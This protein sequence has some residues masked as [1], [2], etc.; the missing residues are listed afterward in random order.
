MA[1]LVLM[2]QGLTL[3]VDGGFFTVERAGQVVDRVRVSEVDEVLLFGNVHVTPAATAVLLARGID[4]VFLSARGRYRGRL[5][6]RPGRNVEL[7]IAQFERLR[8]PAAALSF[9]R[10]VVAGKIANQRALLL[11]AQR[12]HGLEEVA[13]ALA[14]LRWVQQAVGQAPNIEAARG[15]EG[16]A[17]AVYFGR[18]GA[19][20]RNPAF[21]FNGRTRRPPRDPVNAMLSFGYTMLATLV[22]SVVLRAGLDP[23]LGALHAPDYGRPSLVLDLME[24]FRPILVDALVLRL[25]NRREVV[26]EDFEQ[27]PDEVE[28]VWAEEAEGAVASGSSPAVWLGE[29]GRRVFFRAWSR[30]LQETH[31]YAP[32]R[33]RLTFEEIVQQQTYLLARV[34]RGEEEHYQA[35]VVR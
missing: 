5:T 15:L 1:S 29:T 3:A 23:M 31:F 4:T 18:L 17:S 14:S 7:R 19:C 12:E 33:Q 25:V 8:D 2:E 11:R 32:R 26:P 30:R 27:P 28:A 24:E 13:A 9:A 21:A 6:G 35:F 10:A 34:L 16:Q 22:E 20:I